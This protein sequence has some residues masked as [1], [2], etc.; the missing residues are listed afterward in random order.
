MTQDA[1]G[2]F[3]GVGGWNVHDKEL[4][5]IT[6]G[7]EKDASAA[8]TATEAGHNTAVVDVTEYGLSREHPYSGLKASPPCGPWTVAGNGAG[9]R[10]RAEIL[11]RLDALRAHDTLITGA[12]DPE[13]A[14]ILEPARLIRQAMA[15]G[16]PFRWIVMEQTRECLPVWEKYAEWL[17]CHGY[18]VAVGNLHAEQF[19]VPQTR[20]RSVLLASRDREAKLPEPTHTR[21][22]TGYV[23][24][25]GMPFTD[26]ERKPWVTMA[27]ALNIV[28]PAPGSYLRSNYGTGGVAANRGRRELWKPAPTITRK[29]NRNKWVLGAEVLGPM[30]DRQASL[31]QTFPAD[32]PWQGSKTE[33]QLQIGNAIPPLLARAILQQVI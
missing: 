20:T 14:L 11:F 8:G 16:H 24:V 12:L 10:E 33:V 19:G 29:Y 1:L 28:T 3:D 18:S 26:P 5:I 6:L 2:L 7:L 32:Y 31:L 30:T 15:Y 4:G 17:R 21:F 9:R 23:K 13:A 22:R 25:T 27:E